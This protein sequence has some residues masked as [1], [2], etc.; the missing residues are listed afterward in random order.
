MVAFLAELLFDLARS[1]VGGW[2]KEAAFGCAGW[3]DGKVKG[4]AARVAAGL[5]LGLA[6]FILIPLV[7]GLLGL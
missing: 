6:L 3:L 2:L 4:R 1:L 7:T 5:S